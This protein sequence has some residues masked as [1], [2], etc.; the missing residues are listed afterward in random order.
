MSISGD[1]Y[2]LVATSSERTMEVCSSV[3]RER[4]RPKS[5]ILTGIMFVFTLAVSVDENIAGLKIPVDE[6]GG[7]EVLQG[8]G[9]LIEDKP[10]MS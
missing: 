9:H 7:V 8:F 3:V 4:T 10:N 1:L 5:H 2:H 6:V